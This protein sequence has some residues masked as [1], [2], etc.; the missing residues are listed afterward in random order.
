YLMDTATK[1]L[2][3]I[4]N[5]ATAFIKQVT[6]T[7]TTPSTKESN[8][9]TSNLHS[10]QLDTNSIQHS[11]HPFHYHKERQLQND[12]IIQLKKAILLANSQQLQKADKQIKNSIT[13]QIDEDYQF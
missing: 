6:K 4:K 13:K 1:S 5:K 12:P 10:A 7:L 9:P 11:K 3:K 8:Q 2:Q